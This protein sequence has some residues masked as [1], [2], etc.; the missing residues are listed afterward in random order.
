MTGVAAVP[1]KH[2]PFVA[3]QEMVDGILSSVK[4]IARVCYDLT[5]KPP[6]TTEWE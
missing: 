2:L 6:A 3:L 1:G 4:G 5:A